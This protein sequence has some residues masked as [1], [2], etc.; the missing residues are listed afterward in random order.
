M[1][2]VPRV[3]IVADDLTGAMDAAAPLAECGLSTW[4]V[5]EAERFVLQD[6]PGAQVVSINAGS[7]HLAREDAAQ[8]VR[9]L[10]SELLDAGCEILIKK[11]DST[12]RGNAVAETLAMLEGS[13]RAAA[14]VAPAFPRQGR[15]LVAGVVCVHGVPLANT[16][17]AR[18]TL[19]PPPPEPLHVL[20]RAA[21]PQA[22]VRLVA[23][24]ESLA[25][26]RAARR[27]ILVVDAASDEDLRSAV[28]SLS[29]KLCDTLLVGSAGIA[30]AVAGTCFEPAREAL[31]MPA[32]KGQ[33]VFVVGS[34]TEQSAQQVRALIA[35]GQARLIAAPAGCVD[36]S[37]ALRAPEASLVIS[38]EPDSGGPTDA[39]EVARR[40][41]DAVKTLIERRPIAALV[42]TGGDTAFAVLRRLGQVTL[43]VMGNLL[44]GIPFGRVRCG[45][46]ELWL[47]TKAGGFGSRDALVTIAQRL[48][49]S[50]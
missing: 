18:D 26:S 5:T 34:R 37:A 15:T 32:V 6:L 36:L 33:L 23:R 1:A 13:G 39:A 10:T 46:R 45:A 42:A 27:Q 47:V 4:V 38:A 24:G 20:F 41:A 22:E 9:T 40:L 8:R 35:S 7:R 19:S 2:A 11:I 50:V 21:A 31:A 25:V 16:E 44:P 49:G 29:G 48:R 43:Q 28:R 14:V 3:I 30:E 12:L 17:L